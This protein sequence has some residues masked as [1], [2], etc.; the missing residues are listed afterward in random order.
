M[1]KIFLGVFALTLLSFSSF[2]SDGGKKKA[3]KS[4]A[5]VECTRS[6]TKNCK[7]DKN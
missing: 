6:C 4:K 7:D 2:A 1:K 5:K 3:K